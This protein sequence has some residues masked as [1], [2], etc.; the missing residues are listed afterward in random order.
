M[1]RRISK[2]SKKCV[3]NKIH[4][5]YKLGPLL[6]VS[7]KL[8]VKSYI[9]HFQCKHC[10]KAFASHAAHDSHMRRTHA[11]DVVAKPRAITSLQSEPITMLDSSHV[12]DMTSSWMSNHVIPGERMTSFDEG[13]LDHLRHL[14]ANAG[15]NLRIPTG[16]TTKQTYLQ[17][18]D[19]R[20]VMDIDIILSP[21]VIGL[22]YWPSIRQLAAR[23]VSWPSH[24]GQSLYQPSM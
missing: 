22:W 20:L 1:P 16:W 18:R 5:C 8:N 21:M 6:F 14:S 12:I 4:K 17:K 10:K 24:M 3:C 11:R 15:T 9:Y 7:S 23:P 19:C 2:A 13:S